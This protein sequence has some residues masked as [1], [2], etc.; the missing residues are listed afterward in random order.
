MRLAATV[1]LFGV[2]V[3]GCGADDGAAC[4]E[5]REPLDPLSGQHILEAGTSEFQTNPPTSGP[6]VTAPTPS[7]S[8][9]NPLDPAL[10]VRILEGGWGR[11]PVR[12][13]P[14]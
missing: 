4:I 3:V 9:P 7:G 10:Q 12:R 1:A 6:H 8:V 11:D 2:L 14:Q 13:H 5:L